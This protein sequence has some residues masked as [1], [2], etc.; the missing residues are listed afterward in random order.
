[1]TADLHRDG[2]A[3]LRANGYVESKRFAGDHAWEIAYSDFYGGPAVTLRFDFGALGWCAIVD[4]GH[5]RVAIA[6]CMTVAQMEDL[7]R[8]LKQF[9]F[10]NGPRAQRSA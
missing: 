4:N 6:V 3:W 8:C 1:M 2:L 7:W 9:D 5:V 10:E